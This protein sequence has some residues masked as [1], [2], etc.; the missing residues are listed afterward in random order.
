MAPGCPERF[1]AEFVKW[2]LHDGRS[3]KHRTNY[4]RIM[5]KYPDKVITIRNQQQLTTYIEFISC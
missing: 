5:K 2:I 3:K 1:D 4:R